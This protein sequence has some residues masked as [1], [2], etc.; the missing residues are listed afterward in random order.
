MQLTQFGHKTAYPFY[1]TIGNIPKHIRRQPSCRS[2]RL[3]AYLPTSKLQH[4]TN[5]ASRWHCL[6]NIFHACVQHI[7]APLETLGLQG[8]VMRS[9]DGVLRRVHLIVAVYIAE[10]PEQLLIAG[11]KNGECPKCMI[12]HNALGAI[13]DPMPQ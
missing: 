9:S 1:V 6:G 10:Y 3:L 5:A 12:H 13:D 4:V 7:L 2:Q 8:I 11:V